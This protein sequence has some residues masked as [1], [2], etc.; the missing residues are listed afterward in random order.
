MSNLN[1][2]QSPTFYRVRIKDGHNA[3]LLSCAQKCLTLPTLLEM[4]IL[5]E[6]SH[7][8]WFAD[9]PAY[10]G[11]KPIILDVACNQAEAFSK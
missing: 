11:L 3:C 6:Q 4:A 9:D 5:R 2:A 8:F 1:E 10:K 7:S